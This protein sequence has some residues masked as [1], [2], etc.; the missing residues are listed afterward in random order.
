ML[1]IIVKHQY[2]KEMNEVFLESLD[3]INAEQIVDFPTKGDNTL[4]LLLTNRVSLLNK[5]CD[6][7]GFG[8]HQSAIL[9]DIECHPKKQK[10]ISRKIYLWNKANHELLR[11]KH[12]LLD[13]ANHGLPV[14]VKSW[15][16]RKKTLP[17][18]KKK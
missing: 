2:C 12:H 16:E 10:P 15:F 13:T 9:A 7:P 17:K 11:E 14:I 4:D 5:C 6:I 1:K 8:D 18:S 3:V